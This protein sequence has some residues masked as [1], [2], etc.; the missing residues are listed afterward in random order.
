MEWDN[1]V[2]DSDGEHMSEE[3]G[4][5]ALVT[6]LPHERLVDHR[7]SRFL[8]IKGYQFFGPRFESG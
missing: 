7:R 5:R 1:D 2:F 8:G 4:Q 3:I 6:K